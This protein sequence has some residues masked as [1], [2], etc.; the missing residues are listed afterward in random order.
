MRKMIIFGLMV[1]TAFPAV[2][3]AQSASDVRRDRNEYLKERRD[4]DRAIERGASPNRVAKELRE[5]RDAQRDYRDTAQQRDRDR[6]W[7]R[8]DRRDDRRDWERD[9]RRDWERDQ[10]RDWGRDDWRD[11]RR[12]NRKIY[13]RGNWRAPWKYERFQNGGHIGRPYYAQRYWIADPWRYRLP[14]PRGYARWV[15]HYDDVLLVDTR[16][17]RVIDVIR[18]FFW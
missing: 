13:S 2:A 10:R 4:V 17:G 7:K 11:Y 5:A 12:D 14:Q 3:S 18:N 9:K 6:N 15:R 16:R 8:D 1:A